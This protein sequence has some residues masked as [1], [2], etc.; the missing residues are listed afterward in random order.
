MEPGAAGGSSEHNPHSRGVER[1]PSV[2]GHSSTPLRII[3]NGPG[4]VRQRERQSRCPLLLDV[5]GNRVSV[6]TL[7]HQREKWRAGQC[8]LDHH[9]GAGSARTGGSLVEQ[10]ST[11]GNSLQLDVIRVNR[12]TRNANQHRRDKT[13]GG[14]STRYGNHLF[15]VENSRRQD[16]QIEA[17]P[18][19]HPRF[20]VIG[21]R[22]SRTDN[23]LAPGRAVTGG[24]AMPDQTAQEALWAEIRAIPDPGSPG[25][26]R[27]Q[28][29][30][31]RLE[32]TMRL[33]FTSADP[34]DPVASAAGTL[35]NIGWSDESGAIRA[36]N[37]MRHPEHHS[38]ADL[39]CTALVG[40]HSRGSSASGDI[41]GDQCR[42]ERSRS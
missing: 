5:A 3:W 28:E 19:R 33:I 4:A 9:L 39:G 16:T 37:G 27:R 11:D 32:S 38:E 36:A 2:R 41:G 1:A 10:S 42:R 7:R 31:D 30:Q 40:G 29:A 21:I 12:A 18:S 20:A 22:S 34:A 35:T 17:G 24:F 23:S 14:S 13:P 6:L 25:V 15:R 8:P 26:V